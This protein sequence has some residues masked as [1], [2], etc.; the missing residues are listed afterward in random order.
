[1]DS[2]TIRTALGTLQAIPDSEEAW[3]I[4]RQA[5]TEPGG[6][7]TPDELVRL[8]DAAR[9]KHVGRGEWNAVAD[10]LELAAKAAE[11]S[12]RE[13]EIVLALAKALSDELF[14]DEAAAVWYLRL[15]EID[16]NHAEA[17]AAM[18]DSESKRQ[19]F[20]ELATSY[21]TEAERAPDEIYKSSM[22]M[23]AAEMD[24]R[25]GGEGVNLETAI[26]RLE[27]AVRL[28]PT[29]ER[30]GR[31]LEHVYRGSNRWEELARV[32][33]RLADRSD[34]PGSRV[35]AGVRLARLYAQHMSDNER[36]A[37][38]YDRVLR[39]DAA[40]G[41]AKEFLSEFYSNES[42]WADLVMLYERELRAKDGSDGERLGEML[43]I[44]ML[45]W[46]KLE[47]P[48]DAEPWFE[49]VRKVDPTNE[50]M[51]SFYREYYATLQ[52]DT[53]LI[54]VLSGAQR[55]MPD[56]KKEK[57]KLA[58]EIAKLAEGTAN[59]QKAIE[60]YKSILRQD[61][62]NDEARDALKRLYKQT[63]GYNALVE[64]L[65]QQLERTPVEEYATRLGVLRE[66]ATVYR[67]YVRS[68][69]ALLSVLNQIVQLD[70]KLDEHDVDEMRELVGLYDKLGRHRDLLTHQLKLA[71]ITPDV[72]EKKELYRAA[73]RRW[74]EQFSNAQNAAD[75]YAA[76]LKL[77]PT[78]AEARERLEDLYRK[79]RAWDKLFDLY[80]ADLERA[81][82]GARLGLLKELATLA[83]ERLN[84]AAE[85]IALYKQILELEPNRLETVD[86]LEKHAE[87]A[88]DWPTL[89]EALELRVASLTDEAQKLL[90]LQ[91]LGTV[92]AEHLADHQNAA[93]TWQRVLELSP[94]HSRA[95][96]VLR[97]AYLS[98]GDFDGLEALYSSQKDWEGLAE[99]LS[100]AADRAKDPAQRIDLSYRAAA[101]YEGKLSQPERAFRSYDRVLAADPS[102]TRAARAL[103]PLYER[104][105]KWARLPPLYELLVEKANSSDEQI[106]LYGKLV[107]VASRR[108][109]DKKAAA[110]YARKAYRLMPDN[111]ATFELLEEAS[112]S[113][114]NW[115]G[116]VETIEERLQQ[117]AS[118]EPRPA[119]SAEDRPAQQ[120]AGKKGKKGKKKGGDASQAD[121]A[122]APAES[123]NPERRLLELRLARVLSEELG[124]SA[125]A[126]TTYKQMLERDPSD[127]EAASALEGILR[128][129]DRRDDL[130]WLLELRVKH[131][132]H[133]AR[134]QILGDWAALEEDVFQSPER[135]IELYRRILELS[136]S[137]VLALST[138]P[139][140]LLSQNDAAGA[141][142][143]IV[144]HRDQLSGD[145]RAE[146]EVELAELYLDRLSKPVQAFESATQ[147]VDSP[148]ASSRAM[149]VLDRLLQAPEVRARAAEVLADRYAASNEPRR[150]AHALGVLLE[151]APEGEGRLELYV[152]VADVHEH[153]LNAK[154]HALD[155][156]LEAVR[157]YPSEL[158]L[159]DRADALAQS[160]GRPTDL[161]EAVREVLRGSLSEELE[162]ELSE[163][164]ARLY[165]DRLGD[166]IGAT[167][168]LERVLTLSPSNE[169]AFQRLKDILTGAERWSELEALYDRASKATSDGARQIEML[170][171]VAL[172]CEE[173]TD[174]IE[175]ATR[176][177]ER[178]LE[179]DSVHDVAIR[180]LD[181]LYAR[182]GK[183]PKLAAL[184]DKR[185][186]TAVGDE[187]FELKLRLSKLLL[188]LHEPDRAIGHVEDVL[189][190]RVNDFQAR[191]LA[192]RMLEIGSLRARAARMLEAVYETRDEIRDLV[193]VLDIRLE[194]FGS[195]PA[196]EERRELLR[197]ISTLRDERLH[198]D[199]G[200]LN[201]LAQLVPADP[202]DVEARTRMLEIGRRLGAHERVAEVLSVAAERAETNG[203]RGEILMQVASICQDLLQ[204]RG[205][206]E[207]VYR[208]VLA[209]DEDDA[210]LVLPASRALERIYV[211]AGENSKLAEMLRVQVKH[212][213][214]GAVR[215][216][217]LGRLGE[218]CQGVLGDN[219][220]AIAAWKARVEES[221]DDL[222]GLSALDRLFETTERYRELV[223]VLERRREASS[224]V[225]LRKS[226]MTRQ[227]ETLWKKLEDVPVAID[228]YQALVSEFG[229]S[230]ASF[231][232]L[233]ALYGAA[234]R[235]DELSETI[236]RHLDVVQSDAQRLELLAKLGDLK[237]EHLSDVAGSL[238][239]YRRA[240]SIDTRHAESRA[241]LEK[242]LAL[243]DA[244]SRR[245]AAQILH[246]IYEGEGD[247][248]HLLRVLE[249]EV[250]TSDDTLDKIS[251]L[252]HAMR[253]AEGPLKDAP[254]AFGFAERAVR[255]AVGHTDLEPWF[256]HMERLAGATRR[257]AEYVKLLCDVVPEIFDGEVQ[258]TVTLKIADLARH[259]LADRELARDYYKK[260]LEL[261]AD[262]RKALGA[263]ESLYE[264]TGDAQNLLEILE[265]RVEVAENDEERKTLLFRRARLLS[266]VLDNKPRAIEV[267]ESILEM[268]LDPAALGALEKL[269]TAVAQ[270][271]DLISLYER[272]I[273]SSIGKPADLHVNIARVAARE[274]NDLGRAFD[275]LDAALA[276]D[277]K[278]AGVIAELER[279]LADVQ[280]PEHRARAAALL[281]PVYLSRSDFVRVM[282]AIRARLSY[283]SDS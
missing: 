282:D 191:E 243:D 102:D 108:L 227:A 144:R 134:V 106:E 176:Y 97:E 153:K 281:E 36:A 270:W 254:R 67:Q 89:A 194:S 192:E 239:V 234:S 208:R 196:N 12:A 275:E 249:I 65:R 119:S 3:A 62:D 273:D 140:L 247:H 283:V 256:A 128:R 54:D 224:D 173:I 7:I 136:D 30:A 129:E 133:D 218:L 211:A 95:L 131:A 79:R 277:P 49:R 42:R 9:V 257:Q 242:L 184:L 185:L 64:L 81:E 45:H 70:D 149:A 180:A 276:I 233:E 159:W 99:V 150:E 182:Q 213:Q 181:R 10:L 267:Y 4:L 123:G 20:S 101:V 205:R 195:D 251:I 138:L 41:E 259:Q 154:S 1:M 202:L 35:A 93:R 72:E 28:D 48:Q 16:P 98:G 168:Y 261:R 137:D 193:R 33:E 272:Q 13:P 250:S 188:D 203:A 187:A 39:V 158:S 2:Q 88:K 117:I 206:A 124:R 226:L 104:E 43:Q 222:L 252:E 225:E 122:P 109:N 230:E 76:L 47:R 161:A 237:R 87:R 228:A 63:Q 174:D 82:G 217:L 177:Y 18:E 59:A 148:R 100:G 241:A 27:Q 34:K 221:P 91:K 223:D 207:R 80:S 110:A 112:R 38:A 147:A 190:E 8:F 265:R 125:D 19:R 141:A 86:A 75:A 198:D 44:A 172:I 103:I 157:R 164:A 263:L 78:D 189:R 162:I 212:E 121:A 210:E 235:W 264:E 215:R 15:L 85:A 183:D 240:L 46:R 258:L 171:E 178:I 245:E 26:E 143:I 231:G 219:D 96:R 68:D 253:V 266:D 56:G 105:E 53:R 170:V 146:R 71:E 90:A 197:R 92:Y 175:K 66:V 201:T 200:A 165:E 94:G 139:R 268:G 209:L 116:L 152:R 156:V 166:A 126:V 69:T 279:I 204:D 246:P 115:E 280:E 37:R 255:A 40:H 155:I 25:Y 186:E 29:N 142:E 199:D 260:S 262:D 163:R 214:D 14:D 179:I 238:E 6:D 145:E 216:E 55:A 57:K 83:A 58:S 132:D 127:V 167:P 130:R 74:L 51:L 77:A 23:R 60:Q 113:A 61:A 229:P 160:T 151:H 232:A 50:G 32:L 236:D 111:P 269:Y 244:Q 120:P 31:L 278:H 135:A 220:G 271:G 11:G 5:V 169:A 24:V 22:L 114:G 248:E 118:A 274:Q 73:A 17:H 21:A 107:D 52:D 84:R